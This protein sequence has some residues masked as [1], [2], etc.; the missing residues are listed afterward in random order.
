VTRAS[1]ADEARSITCGDVSMTEDGV[2]TGP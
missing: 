2:T 1:M